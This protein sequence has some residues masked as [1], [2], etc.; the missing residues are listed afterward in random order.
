[1][2]SRLQAL[3]PTRSPVLPALSEPA[4]VSRSLAACFAAP[5]GVAATAAGQRGVAAEVARAEEDWSSVAGRRELLA[6]LVGEELGDAGL[7]VGLEG[8]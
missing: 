5:V 7:P 8:E 6:T 1:M 2:S 3:E 4:G